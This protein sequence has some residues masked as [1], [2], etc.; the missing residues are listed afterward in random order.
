MFGSNTADGRAVIY[1]K[2]CGEYKKR[3]EVNLKYL[4]NLE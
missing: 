2:K 1:T 3:K 4:R